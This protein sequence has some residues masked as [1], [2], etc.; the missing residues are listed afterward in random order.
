MSA[1]SIILAVLF[2]AF[3]VSYG[4]GMR[5]CMIGGEKGALVPGALLGLSLSLFC[6]DSALRE[7]CP[8][9]CAAGALGMSFGGIEPYAQ[10]MSYI[11]HRDRE[12]YAG[13]FAKGCAGIFL[14]GMLWFGIAGSILG[15]LPSALAGNL[16]VTEAVLL[17]AS[18]PFV[19]ILGTQ[20]INKP[21]DKEKKIFPK[22]YLSTGSREEWG[23]NLFVLAELLIFAA[24]KKNLFA[25]GAA[26]VG[27]LSG[28]TGFLGGLLIYDFVIRK[29]N[30]K[31]VFGSLN[32]RGLIDG[33]KIMEHTFG[34]VGGG[35]VTL[36]FCLNADTL[37][38]LLAS[39]DPASLPLGGERDVIGLIAVPAMLLLTAAQYP[40][41]KAPDKKGTA[42]DEHL[43]ELLERPFWD[44]FPLAFIFLGSSKAALAAAFF[45]PAYAMCEK[46]VVEWFDRYEGRRPVQIAI[47]LWFIASAVFFFVSDGMEPW[48]FAA[49][50]TFCY[51]AAT[52][53]WF[54][55]PER[56]RERKQSKK[57]V[58]EFYRSAL[59]VGGHFLLQCI[60]ITAVC[61]SK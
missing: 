56:I 6:C 49:L 9:F 39:A 11:L 51:T 25:L 7:L 45:T 31:Y 58:V 53:V 60:V 8:F 35:G 52:L 4:W 24:V 44:M 15:L 20:I 28:G 59:T 38:T 43:F 19:S 27:L 36:Y 42:Y 16:S 50:Y 48:I 21:Y 1:G 5:G 40:I 47:T 26:G 33:W 37:K 54:F 17:F 41:R 2:A 61:L 34:A 32:E 14:K 55:M 22:L 12:P 57:S 46:C 18:L 30:G 23:G 29:H 10:T 3:A 13:H